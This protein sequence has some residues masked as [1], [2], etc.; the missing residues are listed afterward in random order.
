MADA[1][2]RAREDKADVLIDIAT[3]TGAAVIAPRRPHR[4][5]LSNDDDLRDAIAR[6]RGPRRRDQADAA[7]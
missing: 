3:L 7:A 6:R 1:L 2:V 5:D 4:R